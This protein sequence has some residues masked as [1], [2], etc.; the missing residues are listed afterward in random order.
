M[1]HNI[2]LIFDTKSKIYSHP[3][4]SQS[5]G[6]FLRALDRTLR[7]PQSQYALYPDDYVAYHVGEY[8]DLSGQFDTSMAPFSLGVLRQYMPV[9]ES[10]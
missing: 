9:K 8:D 7:D 1:K 4:F 10:V 6:T 5:N 3:I 2:Y